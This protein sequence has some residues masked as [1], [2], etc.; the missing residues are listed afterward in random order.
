MAKPADPSTNAELREALARAEE[1]INDCQANRAAGLATIQALNVALH[2]AKASI[3]RVMMFC[4]SSDSRHLDRIAGTRRQVLA[5]L[6]GC[7]CKAGGYHESDNPRCDL[8]SAARPGATGV[9][10]DANYW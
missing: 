1:A 6:K 2:D 7:T 5:A 3:A 10:P 4:Q 8:N 9:P